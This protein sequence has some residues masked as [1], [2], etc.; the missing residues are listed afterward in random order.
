[1]DVNHFGHAKFFL[2]LDFV[3]IN[4]ALIFMGHM[5]TKETLFKA[6]EVAWGGVG[7]DT[8]SPNKFLCPK[9]F[10]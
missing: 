5:M 3:P 2:L 9:R 6:E 7:G 10:L 4:N 1:M 8:S